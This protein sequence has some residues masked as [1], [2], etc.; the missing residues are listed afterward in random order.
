MTLS[1]WYK[2]NGL[3]YKSP[4]YHITNKYTRDQ[5]M[6]LQENAVYKLI[7]AWKNNVELL[8]VDECTCHPWRKQL[9]VWML[10]KEPFQLDLAP[11][12]KGKRGS[13]A[14]LGA[15]SNK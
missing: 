9:K 12:K 10:K 6:D 15:I 14:V 3:H 8:F 7:H 13:V 5:M 1:R 2:I 11:D 4:S